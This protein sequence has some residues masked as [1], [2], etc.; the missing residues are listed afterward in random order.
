MPHC[1][2]I[3]HVDK[4]DI[5]DARVLI[6]VK[7]CRNYAAHLLQVI[8]LEQLLHSTFCCEVVER[9]ADVSSMCL[10]VVGYSFVSR[11]QVPHEAHQF[12]EVNIVGCNQAVLGQKVRNKR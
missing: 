6:V 12:V 7:G 2:L 5:I 11:C 9:L 1:N 4:E 3:I 8:Q 10:I